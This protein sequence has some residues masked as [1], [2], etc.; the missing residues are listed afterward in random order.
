MNSFV[1]EYSQKLG[2]KPNKIWIRIQTTKC[3]TCSNNRNLSFN[4]KLVCLPEKLIK[5]VVLHEMLHLKHKRHN[6][7]FWGEIE[8]EF[9]NYKEMET[10]L[11]EYWFQTEILLKNLSINSM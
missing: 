11:L 4:P 5:Y 3:A 6:I 8:R 10:K 1:E 7:Y 2:E 9:P